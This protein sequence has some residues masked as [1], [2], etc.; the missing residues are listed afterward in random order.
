[1]FHAHGNLLCLPTDKNTADNL[2]TT[3]GTNKNVQAYRGLTQVITNQWTGDRLKAEISLSA[4]TESKWRA[5]AT[6]LKAKFNIVRLS[7]CKHNCSNCY[8]TS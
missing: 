2:H 4:K 7:G 6:R 3:G 8:K 1:M 5:D